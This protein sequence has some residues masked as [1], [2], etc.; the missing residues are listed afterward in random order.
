MLVPSSAEDASTSAEAS[1]LHRLAVQEVIKHNEVSESSTDWSGAKLEHD[2]SNYR[3]LEDDA[4]E[5]KT[6]VPWIDE[7]PGQD[8]PTLVQI[9][10]RRNPTMIDVNIDR[11][12]PCSTSK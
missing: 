6:A 11:T 12:E 2:F 1:L 9:C 8:T 3:P 4:E 10:C 5:A 7:L